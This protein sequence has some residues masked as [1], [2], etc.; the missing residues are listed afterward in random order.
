MIEVN[1]PLRLGV[2]PGAEGAVCIKLLSNG[3]CH[4]LGAGTCAGCTQRDCEHE[5]V[6]VCK[7]CLRNEDGE[8][9][10]VE[11]N[12]PADNPYHHRCEYEECE[13]LGPD[14]HRYAIVCRHCRVGPDAARA[15]RLMGGL[16]VAS[17]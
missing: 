7:F 13:A 3:K 9:E 10:G 5:F 6:Q 2:M 1:V 17:D 4:F 14:S 12:Y 11:A 15:M 8:S 16:T